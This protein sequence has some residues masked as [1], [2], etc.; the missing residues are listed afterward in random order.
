M[1]SL[2]HPPIDVAPF[3]IEKSLSRCGVLQAIDHLDRL[4]AFDVLR[5]HKRV[6]R[7]TAGMIADGE[8]QSCSRRARRPLEPIRR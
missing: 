7:S 8:E 5:Q 6:G 3:D 1:T 4:V 2:D